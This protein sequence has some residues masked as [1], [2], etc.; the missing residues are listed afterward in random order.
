M[1]NLLS[2]GYMDTETYQFNPHLHDLWEISY[3]FS[4]TGIS[5]IG[6]REIPFRPGTIICQPPGIPHAERAE[7]GYRNIYFSIGFLDAPKDRA[8]VFTDNETRIIYTLLMQLHA[9]FHLRRKNWMEICEALLQGAYAY[10]Q[11]FSQERSQNPYVEQ[12][13][14]LLVSNL[15]NRNASISEIMRQIPVSKDHARRLFFGETGKTPTE[16]LTERRML[17][18]RQLIGMQ[19]TETGKGKHRIRIKEIAGMCGFDDPYYFS[20]VFR[21][22]TGTSPSEWCP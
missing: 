18:A 16:Y 11:S 8:L 9:E 22:A 10:M 4:G 19:R 14:N 15:S 13:K 20:K 2:I 12:M 5:T 6:D 7:Q 17:Y 1:K 21:K 3:Y